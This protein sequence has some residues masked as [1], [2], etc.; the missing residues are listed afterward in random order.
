MLKGPKHYLN[1][2]GSFFSHISLSLRNKIISKNSVLVVCEILRLF[3]NK[4]TPDHKYSLSVRAS[5]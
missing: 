2:H 5:V 4:L 3:V 1:Q